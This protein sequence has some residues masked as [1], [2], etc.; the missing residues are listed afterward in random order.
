VDL[1][2]QRIESARISI[3]AGSIHCQIGGEVVTLQGDSALVRIADLDTL[4]AIAPITPTRAERIVVGSKAYISTPA[5]NGADGIG[6][7][8]RIDRI[9]ATN[10]G[11]TYFWTTVAIP[12]NDRYLAAGSLGQIRFRGQKVSALTWLRDQFANA[13]DQQITTQW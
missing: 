10:A 2:N 8:V 11:R 5:M 3:E 13:S 4:Y 1:L 6:H 9:A 12:N 7:I